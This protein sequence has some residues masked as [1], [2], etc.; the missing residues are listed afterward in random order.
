MPEDGAGERCPTCGG[1][2]LDVEL[3]GPL[4]E[5]EVGKSV[6]DLKALAAHFGGARLPCPGCGGSQSPV[7]LRGVPVDLC[8]Q[9]G[10]LWLDGGELRALTGGRL[11]E[12]PPP[13]GTAVA[14]RP[15][16]GAGPTLSSSSWAGSLAGI[17]LP[18][19][20]SA[21]QRVGIVYSVTL[22]PIAF[23]SALASSAPA[24]WALPAIVVPFGLLFLASR[25]IVVDEE[26]RCV[27]EVV[28]LWRW[29]LT[30][31]SLSFDRV[32]KV[33][34]ETLIQAS[35]YGEYETYRLRIA[36]L[37]LDRPLQSW[38]SRDPASVDIAIA[39]VART[40][41]IEPEQRTDLSWSAKLS[42]T[43]IG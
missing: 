2:H 11:E 36:G 22:V 14:P 4:L 5:R 38:L 3:A 8:L 32:R 37:G 20:M 18:E 25:R 40:L 15:A 24:V 35:R 31:R 43:E 41:G 19:G 6:D 1:H 23:L 10:A 17:G 39:Y 33:Y 12:T 7:T 42:R 13:E 29:T 27:R 26:E 9:C 28:R 21:S 30:E 34:R 16:E